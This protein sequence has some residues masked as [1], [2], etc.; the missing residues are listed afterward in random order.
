MFPF[1]LFFQFLKLY[2]ATYSWR[3]VCKPL[4]CV[5]SFDCNQNIYKYGN[6]RMKAMVYHDLIRGSEREEICD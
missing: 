2:I 4:E 5:Y 1:Q 6:E 3:A